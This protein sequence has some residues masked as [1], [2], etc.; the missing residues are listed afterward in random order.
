MLTFE[1]IPSGACGARNDKFKYGGYDVKINIMCVGLGRSAV[2]FSFVE[3]VIP[4]ILS[5]NC[6]MKVGLEFNRLY[7]MESIKD[8]GYKVFASHS[9]VGTPRTFEYK[10]GYCQMQ[11]PFLVKVLQ[12]CIGYYRLQFDEMRGLYFIELNGTVNYIEGEE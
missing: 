5:H 12:P 3:G 6:Y 8:T 1:K 11:I 9:K 4:K 2:S 7:F 10:K